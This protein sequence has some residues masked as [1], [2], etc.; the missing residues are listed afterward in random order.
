MDLINRW[1]YPLMLES[2]GFKLCRNLMYYGDNSVIKKYKRLIII[3]NYL[4]HQNFL[5]K[6]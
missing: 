1:T 2:K 4:E 5:I 6:L 3:V